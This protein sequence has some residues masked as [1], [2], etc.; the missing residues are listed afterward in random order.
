MSWTRRE[1]TALAEI[2]LT[3][4]ALQAALED[5]VRVQNPQLTDIRLESMTAT[6]TYDLRVP[7]SKRWYRVTYLA[8][9]D[10]PS[11]SVSPEPSTDSANR[12]ARD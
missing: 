7:P 5:H 4:G 11:R 10:E 8:E 12:D 6:E 1:G 3:G 9:G 2:A